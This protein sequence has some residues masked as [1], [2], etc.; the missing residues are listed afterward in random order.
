MTR[1]DFVLFFHCLVIVIALQKFS[2]LL[3][4]FLHCSRLAGL[5]DLYGSC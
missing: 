3:Y 2:E 5:G 1:L 4:F